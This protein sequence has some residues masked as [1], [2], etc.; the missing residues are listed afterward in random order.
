MVSAGGDLFIHLGLVVIVAALF[1]LL[2]R[3][4]KQP[5]LL[6]YIAVGVLITPVFK[7]ITDTSVIE[8]M[9]IIGIAFLLFLVGLE[10]DL[11]KL[12]QE[13]WNHVDEESI[14]G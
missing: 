9:S 1:A 11:K 10:M 13:T 3:L 5:Q 7:I 6:A 8:S 12:K 4:L 2:F 14:D